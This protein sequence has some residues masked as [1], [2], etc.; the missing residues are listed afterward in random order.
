MF[1]KDNNDALNYFQELVETKRF[2][3]SWYA[4]VLDECRA[5]ALSSENYAFIHGLP[6]AN[7]GTWHPKHEQ[8][9]CGNPRCVT[10]A[11]AWRA[12]TYGEW[13]EDAAEECDLC[14]KERQRHN[15]LFSPQDEEVQQPKF[16]EASYVH[17]K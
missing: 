6:T 10:L 17:Q 8:P 12:R 1:L 2:D 7:P 5:G 3:D 14:Q 9:L 15:R 4:C 11:Q 13:K 16:V